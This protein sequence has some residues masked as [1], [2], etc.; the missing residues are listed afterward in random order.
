MSASQV[1]MG[2][3]PRAPPRGTFAIRRARGLRLFLPGRRSRAAGHEDREGVPRQTSTH[4]HP[5]VA[6]SGLA[7]QE[8][9][10]PI[11]EPE[12]AI[13]EAIAYPLLVVTPQVEDD[14]APTR[15]QYPARL[16]Q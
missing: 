2:C 16:A 4:A 5:D 12:P 10:L 3:S 9:Q 14:Q 6:E 8:R 7:H 1:A 11:V 13:A 15:H